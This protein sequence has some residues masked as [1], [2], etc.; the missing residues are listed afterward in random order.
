MPAGDGQILTA[1]YDGIVD[2]RELGRALELLAARFDCPSASLVSFD[3]ALPRSDIVSPIGILGQPENTSSYRAEFSVFDPAPR[4]FANLHSG[5]AST[6]NAMLDFT[7]A[8]TRIFLNEYFRKIGLEECLGG[9][10]S[11]RNGH[12]ALIGIQ[13]GPDRAPFEDAEVRAL[14]MFL[15]HL[16]RA[17]QLRRA[18]TEAEIKVHAL[19]RT[20]DRLAAGIVILGHDGRDIHV[21]AAARD[22]AA[23]ANGLL[24]DRAGVL[25]AMDRGAQQELVRH[26]AGVRAGG[27]G[28]VVR[29][30]RRDGGRPYAVLVAPLPA[31]Q[32]LLGSISPDPC[33]LFL[34]H[35][36]GA[37]AVSSPEAICAIFGLPMGAARLIAALAQGEDTK[38]YA[39]RHGI[40][41]DAVKFHLKTAFER[42]GLRSQAQLMQAV[43]RALSDLVGR[44]PES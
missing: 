22:I 42:T 38:S 13:R 27:A 5:G 30:P 6:T 40:T 32:T 31:P 9:N 37:H 41:M 18:F 12:F 25:Q 1:L 33:V 35:D 36:P 14:E 24:L 3:A 23:Q 4:A 34:I 19:M 11:S 43:A 7:R 10:L 28:G 20:I 2:G 15:P 17:L 8:D 39:E 26:C 16:T 44:R 29:V 21:N